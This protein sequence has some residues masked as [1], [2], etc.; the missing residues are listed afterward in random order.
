MRDSVRGGARLQRLSNVKR[1]RDTGRKYIK[2]QKLKIQTFLYH[3][4]DHNSNNN[5]NNNNNI[6]TC[7]RRV[8]REC[9]K[10]ALTYL[11]VKEW[12]HLFTFSFSPPIMFSS[13]VLQLS[14]FSLQIPS[15]FLCISRVCVSCRGV[16]NGSLFKGSSA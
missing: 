5:N 11:A 6:F 14:N 8:T 2:N 9:R 3:Y 12:L 7:K 15:L 16:C 1:K 13:T 4:D 10:S